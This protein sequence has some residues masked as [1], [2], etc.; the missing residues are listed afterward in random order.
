MEE[1][2][3]KATESMLRSWFV[4][5]SIVRTL[6]KSFSIVVNGRGH[7]KSHRWYWQLE[8]DDGKYGQDDEIVDEKIVTVSQHFFYYFTTC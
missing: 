6:S 2:T 1:V 5:V 7:L 3:L 4:P 8:Q